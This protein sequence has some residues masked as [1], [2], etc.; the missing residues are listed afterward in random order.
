MDNENL[1]KYA[2]TE[3]PL[4]TFTG[5]G[6]T[7]EDIE[8][9]NIPPRDEKSYPMPT[10]QEMLKAGDFVFKLNLLASSLDENLKALVWNFWIR[11]NE[12]LTED[13]E[14]AS[15]RLAMT[16]ETLKEYLLESKNPVLF[17]ETPSEGQ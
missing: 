12:F 11:F 1:N 4:V 17:P 16:L 6:L 10:E 7:K 14:G 3:A 2:K 9:L 15:I 5:E 8:K 13:K